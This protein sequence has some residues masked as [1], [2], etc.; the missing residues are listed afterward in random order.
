V[1]VHGSGPHDRDETIGPNKPFRDLAWG[2]AS[3]GVAVLRYD[4]RTQVHAAKLVAIQDKVTV[5]EETVEDAVA[6][7][8]LLRT[9]RKI[10]A[11][12]IFVLGHSLGGMMIPRIAKHDPE[13]AGFIFMAGAARPMEDVILEQMSY[14]FSRDG[15]ISDQEKAMLEDMKGRVA[16]VKAPG[17]SPETPSLL[18]PYGVPASYWLDLRGYD[19][20]KE[21]TSLKQ[22]MLFLQGGRD[23]QVTMEDFGRWKA[24]L[25]LRDDVLFRTYPALNHLFIAG[26]G[27]STPQEYERPGHV[28]NEVIGDIADWIKK[29]QASD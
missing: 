2:L 19:A 20:P 22:P 10:D 12:S 26:E 1:L 23:Y 18:L 15:S 29:Y 25:S 9:T 17:L 5:N 4:K 24:A 6:A 14:I 21:A 27:K 13:I 16:K 7:V 11:K 8:S 28:A 3:R